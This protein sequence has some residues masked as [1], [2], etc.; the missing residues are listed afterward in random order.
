MPTKLG[1]QLHAGPETG[2]PSALERLALMRPPVL[3]VRDNPVLLNQAYDRIGAGTVYLHYQDVADDL[4]SLIA[5]FGDIQKA[6]EGFLA[7]IE[8][9][10]KSVRW[11]Y[12]CTPPSKT[13][14]NQQVLFDALVVKLAAE[15]FNTRLCIGNFITG[16][17]NTAQWPTYRPA[18]EA[19][20][21]YGAIIGLQERFPLFAY[22]GYGPNA[23]IPDLNANTPRR[24]R[25]E[26]PY[27]QGFSG[28][29]QLV[30]RYRHL[31]DYCLSQKIGL[32][33][34][35]TEAGAGR[36]IPQW[37]DRFRPN[38]GDWRSLAPVWTQLGIRNAEGQYFQDITWLDQ[39]VYG[40]DV[41]LL[42]MC[43]V[44]WNSASTPQAEIGNS[45]ALLDR[46]GLYLTTALQDQ[47][48]GY[49]VRPF[50]SPT[51]YRVEVPRLRVRQ[52]P[53][54]NT[55]FIGNLDYGETLTATHYTFYDGWLWVQH[56]LG[57]SAYAPLIQGQPDYDNKYLEGRLITTP[58]QDAAVNNF[59]GTIE[60]VR[61]FMQA[62]GDHLFYININASTPPDGARRFTVTVFPAKGGRRSIDQ[63]HPQAG[64]PLMTPGARKKL[65]DAGE[66]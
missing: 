15:R 18:L 53:S 36:V 26:I 49:T 37:L 11:A 51:P 13:L 7:Q 41:E 30:G 60:E 33:V 47:P 32:R 29:G 24:L 12:H 31:R 54:M 55:K 17:P 66:R 8:P 19:A 2:S 1:F 27:P 59:V 9:A 23:N 3:L 46:L 4:E 52:I 21:R 48:L 62:Q 45:P 40:Q 14:S 65:R 50:D 61:R 39:H 43:L 10:I 44:A 63:L 22:V 6:A 35:M 34:V 56:R 25:N 16:S 57:W 20:D 58:R 5:R 42:G 38:L 64:D 28:P